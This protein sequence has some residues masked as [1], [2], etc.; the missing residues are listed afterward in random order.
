VLSVAE[1]IVSAVDDGAGDG[2]LALLLDL[3]A[4]DAPSGDLPLLDETAEVLCERL[5]RIGAT[6]RRIATDRGTLVEARLGDGSE[7]PILLLGHYD[8]VWPAGTAASRPPRVS[9]GV[10]TGPGV[11]DMRGGIAAALT[12]LE[13]VGALGALRRPVSVLLT[14][15]EETGSLGSH[16]H[17]VRLGSE[18]SHVLVLE[19][20]LEHGGL[21]TRR[22]GLIT[23]GAHVGGRAAHAGLDPERGVS[24]VSELAHLVVELEQLAAPELGTTVNV[25]VIAGGTRSNVVAAEAAAEVDVRVATMAEHARILEALGALTARNPLATVR[26]DVRHSRPPMERTPAIGAAIGRAAEIF[27]LAGVELSEGAA[28][29]ASDGNLLAPL[30]VAVLDGLGPDGG[31]A[32]ALDEHVLV[33]SLR[34][35]VMLHA[36][37]LAEL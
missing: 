36:L 32:H 7:Q 10:V 26:V 31:G 29:G 4:M 16:E 8:T 1:R 20:P 37:L 28:G 12:A 2:A 27:A 11:Y 5:Q 18:A 33:A 23:F 22:K 21:K 13:L 17:I 3:A 25:G 30:A 15:D 9:D 19:P 6:V 24:A 14:P 34:E 35:R